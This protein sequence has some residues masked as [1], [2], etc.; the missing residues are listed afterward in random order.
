MSQAKSVNY[1]KELINLKD[2]EGIEAQFQ[3]LFNVSIE[4]ITDLENWIEDEKNIRS[5]EIRKIRILNQLTFTISK[6]F[7]H[8]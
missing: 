3:R 1:Y 4:S 5:T 2:V 6:S 7:S 8:C